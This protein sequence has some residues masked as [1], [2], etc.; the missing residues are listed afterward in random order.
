MNNRI[1]YSKNTINHIRIYTLTDNF[2][3]YDPPCKECL[4]QSMCI[5]EHL[6]HPTNDSL[7]DHINIRTCENLKNFINDDTKLPLAYRI[8]LKG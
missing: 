4:I 5:N 7:P 8:D 1:R 6:A 2:M 3:K